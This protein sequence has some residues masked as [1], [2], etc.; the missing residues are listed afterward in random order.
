MKLP[1]EISPLQFA[2]YRLE[3][4]LWNEAIEEIC[5][6]HN[7]P[8]THFHVFADGSNLVV[9]VADKFVVK[10]FPPFHIHQWKSEYKTLKI[11]HGKISIPVPELIA[12]A[13][14]DD[15]W[16]YIIM[17]IVPG[18]T[19][20]SV[21]KNFTHAQ[22]A[23]LLRKIG[24]LMAEVHSLK[25]PLLNEMDPSWKNFMEAQLSGFHAR[26][27]R[28][29]MPEW[30][31][32]EVDAYVHQNISL[33]PE[34][35]EP[36]LL[37]GE[38]TPFNLLVAE[39]SGEWEISAMLDFGDSMAGFAEYDLLGPLLFLTEGDPD[40]VRFLLKGYRYTDRQM[41][42]A[43]RKRLML[44][45]ILHRY[46]NLEFQLRIPG[47]ASRANSIEDLEQLIWPF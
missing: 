14:R 27:K 31:L 42:P 24:M 22:K 47:W 7:I 3:Q 38:Y 15:Q 6:L 10:L 9:S 5:I 33:L 23:I 13:K 18:I 2:E 44:L 8:F 32:L 17:T 35:V 28:L 26:H 45:A 16:M 1:F 29:Q 41:D 12:S 36:V 39:Q 19:L 40:L 4:E 21:W 37:T 20:E 43:L 25:D 46:S 30:F 34:N 11:L